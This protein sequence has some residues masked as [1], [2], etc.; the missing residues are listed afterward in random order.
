MLTVIL[1]LF[2]TSCDDWL[3][4]TPETDVDLVVQITS[5]EGFAEIL[6]GLYINMGNENLYG[7]QL[8]YGI[9]ET[10]ARNNYLENSQWAIWNYGGSSEIMA[11]EEMWKGLYNVVANANIILDNIDD[12][13]D[14]FLSDDYNVVKGEALAIRAFMHFD[15]LRLFAESYNDESKSKLAIPYV[16]T[17][18][19]V[20]Y[21]HLTAEQV[22]TK[23]I[24]DLDAAEA[25]LMESDPIAGAAYTGELL[26]AANRIYRLNYYAV[27]AL[28]ARVYITMGEQALA[29][30]YALKVINEYDWSWITEDKLIGSEIDI[31]YMSEIVSA[32]NVT[33]LSTYYDTYFNETNPRYRTNNWE[34]NFAKI[35]FEVYS[36][37]D[38]YSSEIPNVGINDW[39]YHYRFK[40]DVNGELAISDKYNQDPDLSVLR[41]Q[42]IPLIRISE[43]MLIAAEASLGSD[44][45]GA[46]AL[47][48]DL[49]LHR[50]VDLRE[51]D[52][53][54]DEEVMEE[55]V[56]E[57]R[58][59]LY[60]EG[61][62]FYMY[63][64]LNRT[65]M[66]NM[67]LWTPYVDMAKEN[68]TLPLP[69]NEI[70]FGK[71]SN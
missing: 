49:K 8:S 26:N 15:L 32:L 42:T 23:I 16:E 21:P 60:H 65:E 14:L 52:G 31:L 29:A 39:R 61:Q 47:L 43:L 63:K 46:L 45:V 54:T 19:R 38:P 40:K 11:I 67:S 58:K 56:K 13:K 59:E 64:R 71:L 12:K 24:Q 1:N 62:V 36:K 41:Y 57:S 69:E 6:T 53:A 48:N 30:Q 35:I 3:D 70:E 7:H 5:D 68:Y 28:K 55:I 33:S 20:R 17:F 2:L 4:V 44:R 27:L 51:L 66:P 34:Y 50:E 37:Q 22:Y 18:E 9:I 25:L 10:L